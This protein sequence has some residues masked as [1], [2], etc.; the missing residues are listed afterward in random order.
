MSGVAAN[1]V[2]CNMMAMAIAP[3]APSMSCRT[4]C[5]LLPDRGAGP[6]PRSTM[7]VTAAGAGDRRHD[8]RVCPPTL[9]GPA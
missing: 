9:W 3:S 8:F 5:L 2:P 1:V 6:V 7:A 4:C